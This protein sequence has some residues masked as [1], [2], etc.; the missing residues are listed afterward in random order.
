MGDLLGFLVGWGSGQSLRGRPGL[1]R[2]GVALSVKD[3]AR[4]A[5]APPG[6][7]SAGLG[8]RP[9]PAQRD[10]RNRGSATVACKGTPSP[11]LICGALLPL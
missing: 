8:R 11:P 9:D 2:F 6:P 3:W 4:R 7:I 10:R 5:R 1:K